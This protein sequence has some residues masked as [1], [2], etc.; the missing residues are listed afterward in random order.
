MEEYYLEHQYLDYLESI[1]L[2]KGDLNYNLFD[3]GAK[4]ACSVIRFSLKN[5]NKFGN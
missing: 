3:E 2:D 1:I 5:Q 4:R